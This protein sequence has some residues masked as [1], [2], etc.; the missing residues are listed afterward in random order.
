MF[1]NTVRLRRMEKDEE[2]HQVKPGNF[3]NTETTTLTLVSWAGKDLFPA[4]S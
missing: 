4:G 3:P 2:G 1:F